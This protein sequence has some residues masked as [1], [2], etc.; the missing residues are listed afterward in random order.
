MASR[1]YAPDRS[2]M[3]GVTRIQGVL[4]GTGASAPTITAALGVTSVARTALGRYLITFTGQFRRLLDFRANVMPG[5]TGT[6]AGTVALSRVVNSM[7]PLNTTVNGLPVTQIEVYV[8]NNTGT[9]ALT[10]LAVGDLLTF[11][12]TFQNSAS[13]PSVGD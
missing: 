5:L 1:N 12:A 2:L 7:R 11:E 4:T 6:N 10:E 8:N 3:R 9:E 13:R